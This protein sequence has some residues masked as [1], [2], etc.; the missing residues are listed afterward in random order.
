MRGTANVYRLDR[1]EGQPAYLEVFV[2]AHGGVEQVART[3]GI[4]TFGMPV[5]S[6]SGFVTVTAVREIVLRA[7]LREMPTMVLVLGDLEPAGRDIRDCVADDVQAFAENH[8]GAAIDVRTIAFT[9]EQVD[10][11]GLI[12]QP[13]GAKKRSDYPWW[14][15]DWTVEF[16]AVATDDLA[17]IL[18]A[19]VEGLTDAETRQAVIEREAAERAELLRQ[20]E[21]GDR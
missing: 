10:E 14:P 2:E 17:R 20:M 18:V 16:E 11:L 15:Q 13:T 19:T 3:V 21:E 9:A 6:G 1:Q 5:Y 12:K 8:D 4:D 7:E